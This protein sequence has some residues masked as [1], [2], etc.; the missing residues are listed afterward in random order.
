MAATT[1][2]K[3]LDTD[4]TLGGNSPSDESIA[5]QK[6]IQEYVNNTLYEI[7]SAFNIVPLDEINTNEE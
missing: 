2:F 3:N 5:S 6:A 4:N 7:V 1:K